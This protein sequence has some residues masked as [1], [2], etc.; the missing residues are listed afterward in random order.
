MTDNYKNYTKT[1]SNKHGLFGYSLFRR[2]QQTLKLI[3]HIF[4]QLPHNKITIA[5]MG[6]SDGRMLKSI[7]HSHA[8]KINSATGIDIFPHGQPEKQQGDIIEYIKS[9]LYKSPTYP[10]D[11]NSQDILIASAFFKHH[12]DPQHFLGEC[13]RIL[14]KDGHLLMLDPCPWV[15]TTGGL[16]GH[17]N[18]KYV[19]NRWNHQR[20][21]KQ[22]IK[23][24]YNKNLQIVFYE[25]YWAAPT[26]KLY[27]LGMERILPNWLIQIIGLHQCVLLK[28]T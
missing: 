14:K 6:C 2:T 7:T 19:R 8:Q 13:I 4:N 21:N 3:N 1:R 12:P 16:L 20:L 17:F 18:I 9:D 22:I 24:G 27:Q 10:L 28:K 25:R 15:V 23:F 11:S 5:D 26:R